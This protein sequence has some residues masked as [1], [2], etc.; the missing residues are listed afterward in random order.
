MQAELQT[1]LFHAFDTLNL[2]QMKSFNVPP[3]T[4]HG[5][6]ALA[7][8]GPQAQSRGLRHLFVMVDSFLHQAGM[9][10]GLER[11]LAMKGIAMTLWPCPAGE[12]CVTDV[13]AAVAQLRDARCDG[14]V[15]FGGGS[16]LDAAKAVALLV[17]NPE[18]TLGEMTEHSELRPRLP[19]DRGADHRWHRV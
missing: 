5:V 16:V 7:A 6:G 8:C 19:A 18:Q 17:A 4:L 3:V 15:A 14:V 9:T 12:P 2:Q 11:S 10:A 13:C 1:A